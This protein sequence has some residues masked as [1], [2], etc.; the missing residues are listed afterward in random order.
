AFGGVGTFSQKG[1]DPPEAPV[2]DGIYYKTG[3]L[4]RWLPDGNIEFLGRIDHQVKIRGFRIELGEIENCLLSHQNIKEAVVLANEDKTGDKLLCAYLTTTST[5]ST[6]S[7]KSTM[8]TASPQTPGTQAAFAV[9]AIRE[10]LSQTLPSY[11]I[12]AH[13]IIVDKIPLTANGKVDAKKLRTHEHLETPAAAYRAPAGRNEKAVAEAWQEVLHREKISANDN[14]FE[15]GG[16]SIKGI[17]VLAKLQTHFEITFNDIFETQTLSQLARKITYKSDTDMFALKLEEIKESIRQNPGMDIFRDKEIKTLREKAKK[18]YRKKYTAG[19]LPGHSTVIPYENILLTGGTGY[20]GIHLLRRLLETTNARIHV[21]VRGQGTEDAQERLQ[22]KLD[23]YF[24]DNQYRAGEKRISVIAGD[25]AADCFA[26]P[27]LKYKKLT[28]EIDCIINSAAYVK[29]YGKYED[30]RQINVEGVK[31]LLEFACIGKRKDFNHIS[32]TSLAAAGPN[33]NSYNL[34]SEYEKG[35][36]EPGAAKPGNTGTDE[37]GS[38]SGGNY[39]IESKLEAE[40]LVFEGRAKGIPANIMRVGNL[41]FD[42]GSGRFQENIEDN[43]FYTILRALLKIGRF[44]GIQMQNLEFTFIDGA[45]EAVGLLFSLR[46]L[47]NQT[48]HIRNPF[49]LDYRKLGRLVREAQSGIALE[50]VPVPEFLDYLRDNYNREGVSQ[51]IRPLLLHSGIME[52]SG[53]TVIEVVS[54]KTEAHL[55]ELGF[56]WLQP[57]GAHVEKMLRHGSERKFFVLK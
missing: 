23:W 24:D 48:Y 15:I 52:N 25:I 11:M 19:I 34:F 40:R 53:D 8:S 9:P 32:T 6:T 47:R 38:T 12:P 45:A 50:T 18:I 46:E 13:F 49:H 21:L 16:D 26:L 39:Y 28:R 37:P 20:L 4:A 41:V 42:S 5:T 44:P 1:S 10:Y 56:S 27:Q 55:K 30:F 2:T 17:R 36:E 35:I 43:A 57:N 33:E 51:Y 14:F 22:R 54:E 7:T 29:H 31:R 3:D